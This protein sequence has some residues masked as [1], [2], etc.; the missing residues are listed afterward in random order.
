[1]SEPSR[2]LT[3]E[4]ARLSEYDRWLGAPR[5]S[6]TAM[7]WLMGR[8]GAFAVNGPVFN[9]K[10]NLRLEPWMRVLDIGCGRGTV[11]RLLDQKVQFDKPP[12]GLDF[13]R[14]ML[15]L[16]RSDAPAGSPDLDLTRGLATTLPFA[17][18]SFDLVLSGYLLKHLDEDELR[19]FFI[20]LYRVLAPGG[21]ALL[22]EFAPSGNERLDAW[23]RRV[24]STGVGKPRL[25]S[26]RALMSLAELTGFPY[27]R[28]ARLRPF[29]LPP[30]P[31]AS[32]LVGKPPEGWQDA[33][34]PPA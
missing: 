6:S 27:I 19:T 30:I 21:L 18:E 15:R 9:L 32:V 24:V 33:Q 13:S 20:E 14:S 34:T 5:A 1:M 22:W 25:R 3:N 2:T 28:N 8:A 17:T 10:A 26:S 23:N 31:R 4:A 7:R 12:V 11:L 16:A 29:L